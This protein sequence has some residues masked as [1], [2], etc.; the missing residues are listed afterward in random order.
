MGM[1]QIKGCEKE[2]HR[3][4]IPSTAQFSLLPS[5][6]S[7]LIPSLLTCFHFSH[8]PTGLEQEASFSTSGRE[9]LGKLLSLD[10]A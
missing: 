9:E 6:F 3:L 5:S 2:N 1:R 4:R 7:F 8:C 10:Q